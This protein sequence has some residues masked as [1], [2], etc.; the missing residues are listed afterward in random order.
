MFIEYIYEREREREREREKRERE[1]IPKIFIPK[2]SHPFRI[3]IMKKSREEF[4]FVFLSLVM[5][6]LLIFVFHLEV[7]HYTDTKGRQQSR[8]QCCL[9]DVC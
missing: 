6:L 3:I 2:I 9:V 7:S 4:S 1:F 5:F 8:P